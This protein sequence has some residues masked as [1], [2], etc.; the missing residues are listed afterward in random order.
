MSSGDTII[1]FSENAEYQSVYKALAEE[2]KQ[3]VKVKDKSKSSLFSLFEGD[4]S[5]I[6]Y[7]ILH[8][9]MSEIEAIDQI[10][11]ARKDVPILVLSSY[12]YDTK[13]IVF[14]KKIK[15]FILK[16]FTLDQLLKSVKDII[17]KE[18]T[19]ETVT[20]EKAELKEEIFEEASLESKKLSVLIEIS[21][22]LNA[23]ESFDELFHDIITLSAEALN[24]ERATLFLLDKK[25]NELWSRTGIG[26]EEKEIRFSV[27]SGI[28]G[29]AV[30][31]GK[32]EIIDNPYSSPKFNKDI[33]KITG[34]KTRNILCMPIRNLKGEIIGVFQL[35]NKKDGNF[36]KEDEVF[37]GALA[38]STGITLENSLLQEELKKQLNQIKTAYEEIYISQN[39]I[40][41]ETKL[42]TISQV[43]GYLN[44]CLNELK[45]EERLKKL[46]DANPYDVIL[47]KEISKTTEA[48]NDFLK[49]FRDYLN[50]NKKLS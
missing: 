31:T 12:F 4:Y 13:D 47:K 16:P 49:K 21:R 10:S 38:G 11:S 8:P 5:L 3:I 44:L 29:E 7:E 2:V 36:T 27:K 15:E 23:K 18:E 45:L 1:I 25:T 20:G 30:C 33:D 41:K 50:E 48:Y 28:A 22:R 26:L 42:A 39:Q 32:S 9:V 40:S 14:G 35:L 6:I 34:F 19:I 46:T 24:A 43:S 17:R 37:L